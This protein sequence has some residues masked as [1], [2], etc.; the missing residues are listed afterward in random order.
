MGVKTMETLDL[1]PQ[2]QA[3]ARRIADW[4]TEQLSTDRPTFSAIVGLVVSD[5]EDALATIPREKE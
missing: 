5:I 4:L 2:D 3:G 1:K